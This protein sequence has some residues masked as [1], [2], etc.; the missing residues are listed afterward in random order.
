MAYTPSVSAVERL[1][2]WDLV[3]EVEG[4]WSGV[5]MHGMCYYLSTYYLSIFHGRFYQAYHSGQLILLPIL[6][7]RLSLSPPGRLLA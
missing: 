1:V 4:G 2:Q 3:D 6:F 5:D 7:I